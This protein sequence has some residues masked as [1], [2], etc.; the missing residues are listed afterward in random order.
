M[1]DRLIEAVAATAEL[2]GTQLSRP[3]ATILLDDL[4][5]YPEPQVLAALAKCRRELKGRLTLAEILSRIDDGRPG[6]DEAWGLLPWDEAATAVLT[7]EM[8]EAM[9]AAQSLMHHG[10]KVGARLAFKEAYIRLLTAAREARRPVSWQVSLGWDRAG[11]VGP[12]TDAV[13]RGRLSAAAANRYLPLEGRVT[14][15][16]RAIEAGGVPMPPEVRKLIEGVGKRIPAHE[17]KRK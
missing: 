12:L 1:G 4:Q 6:P 5:A 16:M 7:D 3:A 2:C 8:L 10:D 15:P 13:Q 17:G 11:R 14:E 9:G